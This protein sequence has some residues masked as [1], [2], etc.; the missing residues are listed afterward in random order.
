MNEGMGVNGSEWNK[1]KM[2]A[3]LWW[4]SLKNSEST[5]DFSN[6][7]NAASA[8]VAFDQLLW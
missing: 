8:S 3:W 4:S 5:N 1:Q 6:D 7:E 2:K